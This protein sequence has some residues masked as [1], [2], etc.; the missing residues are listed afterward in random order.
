MEQQQTLK[1]APEVSNDLIFKLF[2]I[3]STVAR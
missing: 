3:Q 1:C 2:E